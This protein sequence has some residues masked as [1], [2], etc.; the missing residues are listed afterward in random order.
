MQPDKQP[1]SM[2]DKRLEN[3][4]GPRWK[5]GESG[6]PQGYSRNRRLT[7][8]IK[9]KLSEP[10]REEQLADAWFEQALSGSYPH[11]REILDRTEGKVA[12]KVEVTETRVDWSAL[13][14]EGDTER[15]SVNPTGPKPLPE[16][17][18]A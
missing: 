18:Q 1:K 13:D 14:N 6:N 5:K 15:P 8:A 9:R 10:G 7:D 17:G 12:S 11:L 3:L 4:V 16:S 2:P